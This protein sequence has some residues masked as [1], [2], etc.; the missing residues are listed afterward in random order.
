MENVRK[1][2]VI[3]NSGV[4]AAKWIFIGLL[5]IAAISAGVAFFGSYNA[6]NA[7]QQ[8][9]PTP[10]LKIEIKTVDELPNTHYYMSNEQLANYNRSA[11][12]YITKATNQ[13]AST[14]GGPSVEQIKALDL[15]KAD[16]QA[17]FMSAQQIAVRME[18]IM[19][20]VNMV[21]V[22]N[23]LE[24]QIISVFESPNAMVYPI[25]Q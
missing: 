3:S 5:I 20:E 18:A 15:L 11:Q 25:V 13:Y 4:N 24:T 14:V 19:P 2:Q 22:Y 21:K 8:P 6:S 1:Q 16:M 10:Q 7:I 12:Q 23:S 9:Q 17:D